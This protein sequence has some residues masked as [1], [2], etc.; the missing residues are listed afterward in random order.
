MRFDDLKSVCGY[1]P[2]TSV[3]IQEK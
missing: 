2:F 3:L 1:K